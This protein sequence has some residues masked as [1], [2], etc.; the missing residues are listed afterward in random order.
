MA[1][2]DTLGEIER[3]AKTELAP[4]DLRAAATI[5]AAVLA[6]RLWLSQDQEPVQGVPALSA[7]YT[8]GVS[9]T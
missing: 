4:E 6:V 7:N 9:G 8:K 1:V 3:L 2:R 5:I